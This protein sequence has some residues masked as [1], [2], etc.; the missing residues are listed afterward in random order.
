MSSPRNTPQRARGVTTPWN[1]WT[2]VGTASASASASP[3]AASVTGKQAGASASA[4][5]ETQPSGNDGKQSSTTAGLGESKPAPI[6]ASSSSSSPSASRPTSAPQQA[7]L[8]ANAQG[9][10][11]DP[12]AKP[13]S[14][15]PPPSK[16]KA[17]AAEASSTLPSPVSS[18]SASSPQQAKPAANAQGKKSDPVAKPSSA[19]PQ[20]SKPTLA[21][22]KASSALP[23]PVPSS[24]ASSPQQ[25]T[26]VAKEQLSSTILPYG[27]VQPLSPET[28]NILFSPAAGRVPVGSQQAKPAAK[29]KKKAKG[30]KGSK[31]KNPLQLAG[32]S[33]ALTDIGYNESK[34]FFNNGEQSYNGDDYYYFYYDYDMSKNVCLQPKSWAIGLLPPCQFEWLVDCYR[35]HATKTGFY[36][37]NTSD[38]E[39]FA[40]ALGAD[41]L[42]FCA[43]AKLMVNVIPWRG[44]RPWQDFLMVA[45]WHLPQPLDEEAAWEKYLFE[46]L[47]TGKTRSG[48]SLPFTAQLVY[49]LN[50]DHFINKREWPIRFDAERNDEAADEAL[51]L[52]KDDKMCSEL[53]ENLVYMAMYKDV[54]RAVLAFR[55]GKCDLC[56]DCRKCKSLFREYGGARLWKQFKQDLISEVS[57]KTR[58]AAVATDDA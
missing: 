54:E 7:K 56:G 12:M 26:P 57:S 51:K 40:V 43:L 19:A 20:P 8:A 24:S 14:A 45:R 21:A 39:A 55:E 37:Q 2:P 9:K 58:K 53:A 32:G 28:P 11:S 44:L 17:A 36:D 49:E 48:R 33:Q 27:Y 25:A 23:S 50:P 22:A 30:S 38:S 4:A 15:T 18:T 29:K 41:F 5:L 46:S 31:G 52:L 13:S 10:K 6:A 47:L 34:D 1:P 35:L 42:K 16:P 3:P